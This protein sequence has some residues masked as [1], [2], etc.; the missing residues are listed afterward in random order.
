MGL[1]QAAQTGLL[2]VL[3][4][5]GLSVS[6]AGQ[7]A[8]P[9][10]SRIATETL[11]I[12]HG[13]ARSLAWALGWTALSVV[14]LVT[15][16]FRRRRRRPVLGLALISLY[17][18]PWPPLSLLLT[19]AVPTSFHRSP[20]RFDTDSVARGLA[21]YDTHCASCHGADGRGEGPA[22]AAQ[23]VWPPT[24][25]AGLM[26]KRAPGELLW[27]ILHGM[28][29]TQGSATMPGF[30]DRLN[31]A[32]VWAL[33]DGMKALSAGD[34]ARREASWPWPVH[35]PNLW[36]TCTDRPSRELD[37]WRGQRLRIVAADDTSEPPREDPRF[38]TVVLRRAPSATR[39]DCDAG[40]INPWH[41]YAA[42][43]GVP[44][45]ALAGTQFI[46]DRGGWLRALHRPGQPDWSEDSLMCRST[47]PPADGPRRRLDGMDGLIARMEAD[48]VRIDGTGLAHAQ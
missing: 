43:A 41:A 25:S 34:N 30:A 3:H 14:L 9:F 35:A 28:K 23:A 36:V 8:W 32:D 39:S 33:L 21:L 48:P 42:I 4:A 24:L 13:L 38:L 29:D 7:P 2:Q 26:W 22:A 18:A 40:G 44:D 31:E 1:A 37:S 15:A 46:V 19:E 10:A 5:L 6:N 17:I 27:H 16:A 47:S 12:D 20:T 45:A 11:V